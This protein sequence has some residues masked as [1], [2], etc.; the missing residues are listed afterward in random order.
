M[1]R[2]V[3]LFAVSMLIG[4]NAIA[5]KGIETGT[6]Y[7]TGDDSLECIKNISLF[8][9]YAKSKNYQD[10]LTFWKKAYADCPASTK[11]IYIYGAEIIKWQIATETDP[12][13]K[14]ALIDELMLL[15]DNRVKYFG[16]DRNNGKDWIVSRKAQDYNI[17]KGE[18]T[19]PELIY[20]WTGEVIDE[21]GENTEPLAI[22]L[23]MFSSFKLMQGD[24]DTYKSQYINDFLKCSA[25]LES[26]YNKARDAGDEK[27]AEGLLARK[28][29]I[30]Q[31]F[32]GSGVAD[33]ETLQNVYANKIEEKK[34]DL[35]FL[36]ETMTLLRRTGCNETDAYIAASVYAYKIAPTAESAMGLGSK[37]FRENDFAAGEKYYTEAIEMSE[38]SEMK[39][40]LNLALAV[41]ASQKNQFTKVKHYCLK[42]IEENPN[43]GRAYM[44]LGQAYANGAK[45]IFPNDPVL[46][47]CV[48]YAVVAKF[49]KAR[50]VQPDIADEANKLINTYVQYFPTKEE[51]F[52]HPEINAGKAFT[53]PGWIGETV[54]IR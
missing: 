48:Y 15:Y 1:K 33:C 41:F 32:A 26:A 38:D 4:A 24:K 27:N 46:T 36:K 43:N 8:I 40:T 25:L 39:S 10:A 13:K 30:E 18:Q 16:D 52:M 21:F 42:S 35:D 3:F 37:A 11:N 12:A 28:T 34:D 17:L 54:I 31:N 6:P 5:Q 22:S 49:E 51:V 44:L 45:S 47:K 20:K 14:D 2:K 53:I 50:Q 29:E 19:K 7:G 9:P 23:Y